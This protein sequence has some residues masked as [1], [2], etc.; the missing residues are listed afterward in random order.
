MAILQGLHEVNHH[1][2]LLHRRD[3]DLFPGHLGLDR[4]AEFFLP[5][6]LELAQIEFIGRGNCLCQS[7]S[8]VNNAQLRVRGH[9]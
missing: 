6:V 3:D 1:L 4:L 2:R 5:H 8:P 9:V 7:N